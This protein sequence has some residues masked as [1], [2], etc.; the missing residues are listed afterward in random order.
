MSQ[1]SWWLC[2]QGRK[3]AALWGTCMVQSSIV[4]TGI[5]L[6]P[7]IM[8][9]ASMLSEAWNC[10]M[11]KILAVE[12]IIF[13]SQIE[14]SLT[15]L[16]TISLILPFTYCSFIHSPVN[17]FSTLI[18][19]KIKFHLHK[20]HHEIYALHYRIAWTVGAIPIIS[21]PTTKW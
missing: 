13:W 20:L 16:Y 4:A 9:Q 15:H 8:F 6:T 17:K 1:N 18:V 3:V 10:T 19:Q 7:G 5:N 14:S 11:F 2:I 21:S 12:P